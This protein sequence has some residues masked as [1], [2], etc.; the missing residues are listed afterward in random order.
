MLVGSRGA[1]ATPS[2]LSL[3]SLPPPPDFLGCQGFSLLPQCTPSL[4][5]CQRH[6]WMKGF[7]RIVSAQANKAR[8][9]RLL[10]LTW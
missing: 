5:A 9:A 6:P 3:A 7:P 10:R 8:W 4:L 1:P 2:S